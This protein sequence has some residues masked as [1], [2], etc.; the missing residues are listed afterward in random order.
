MLAHVVVDSRS[1]LFHTVL[2]SAANLADRD[3]LPYLLHDR[4]TR[5]WGDEDYQGQTEMI[6]RCAQ[7][8]Q[9]CTNR[10]Y[11]QRGW[12]DETIEA[13]GFY[14]PSLA[15]PPHR[16]H[17]GGRTMFM[18]CDSVSPRLSV[19]SVIAWTRLRRFGIR[20]SEFCRSPG[21]RASEEFCRK[22]AHR[23]SP[24]YATIC[25]GRRTHVPACAGRRRDGGAGRFDRIRRVGGRLDR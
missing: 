10:R 11:R 24:R 22:V 3:T 16:G 17:C 6:H 14:R 5:V 21:V 15:R 19:R 12:I 1:K 20:F 7:A 9:D 25:M 23:M 18:R 4:E 13:N 8:A 2:V